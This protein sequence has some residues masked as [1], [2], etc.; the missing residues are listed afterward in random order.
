M[1]HCCARGPESASHL[2]QARIHPQGTDGIHGRRIRPHNVRDRLRDT[3]TSISGHVRMHH[4]G[5]LGG[6]GHSVRTRVTGDVP[7][8]ATELHAK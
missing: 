8:Q 7:A 1:H 3:V 5:F 2:L 6:N 4:C